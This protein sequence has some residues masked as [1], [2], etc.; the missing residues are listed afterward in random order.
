MVLAIAFTITELGGATKPS[1]GGGAV[2]V[3][4]AAPLSAAGD[5]AGAAGSSRAA[6]EPV[7]S[8][9]GAT[10]NPIIT[11]TSRATMTQAAVPA[12]LIHLSISFRSRF[13]VRSPGSP[14]RPLR[15]EVYHIR[16][17]FATEKKETPIPNFSILTIS[18]TPLSYIISYHW[19]HDL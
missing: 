13:S 17:F 3:E 9:L 15:F 4:G 5:A 14:K 8:A 12:H 7:C 11:P 10:L 19:I 6:P 2:A 16:G 1:S 18:R